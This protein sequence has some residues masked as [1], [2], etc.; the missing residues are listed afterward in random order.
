[1]AARPQTLLDW[2]K[3]DKLDRGKRDGVRTAERE[4]IKALEREAKELR[5]TDEI[6]ELASAFF[7]QAKL[8]RRF[9]S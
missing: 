3:R 6:L 7:T 9:K 8:D 4:R 2:V 1:M 5:R